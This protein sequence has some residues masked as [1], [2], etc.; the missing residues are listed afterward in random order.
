MGCASSKP[1]STKTKKLQDNSD[2]KENSNSAKR[3]AKQANGNAR[4]DSQAGKSSGHSV[5][6]AIRADRRLVDQIAQHEDRIVEHLVRA[7]SRTFADQLAATNAKLAREAAAQIAH[8]NHDLATDI[9]AKAVLA[10]KSVP[11]DSSSSSAVKTYKQLNERL[12]TSPYLCKNQTHKSRL[13]DITVS[14]IKE[15]LDAIGAHQSGRA[16]AE[17]LAAHDART[18]LTPPRSPSSPSSASACGGGGGGGDDDAAVLLSRAQANELARIL[19][20]SSR[21]RP[22]VHASPRVQDAYFVNKQLADNSEVGVS[23]REIEDILYRF[24]EPFT[25]QIN[26]A[27]NSPATPFIPVHGHGVNSNLMKDFD[28]HVGG[29]STRRHHHRHEQ[30][31]RDQFI[32]L[33]EITILKGLSTITKLIHIS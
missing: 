2:N 8:D 28:T 31:V 26:A 13:C 11:G 16:V 25:F 23:K 22:V 32:Y 33:F 1:S 3:S 12:K 7:V 10:V 19:F 14:Q 29:G 5:D 27:T 21:A 4:Q 18:Q 20:L 30:P 6:Q 9:V 15:C 17:F 24:D